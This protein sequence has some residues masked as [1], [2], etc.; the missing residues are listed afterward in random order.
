MPDDLMN[1]SGL[2]ARA[3]RGIPREALARVAE[4]GLPGDHHLYITFRTGHPGVRIADFLTAR[5]PEE[6]TIVLQHQFWGLAAHDD[7]FEVTLSFSGRNEP[8]RI[9]YDAVTAF[10]DPAVGFTLNFEGD[11]GDAAPPGEAGGNSGPAPDEPAAPEA[12]SRVIALDAF[13]RKES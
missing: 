7:A 11:G 8:L 13:R 10:T 12:A 1:Y 4:H 6:M 5:Y 9:P 3:M 2:V